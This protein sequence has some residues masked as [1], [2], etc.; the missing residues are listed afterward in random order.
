M[1]QPLRQLYPD[2]K[3]TSDGTA[4][5]EYVTRPSYV[6]LLTT[7]SIIV[8]H[9]LN[10]RSK[11]DTAHAW[12]TWCTPPGPQG[13]LWLRD[14]LPQYVPESRIFLYEY[15]STAAYG[16]DRDTFNGKANELLEAIRIERDEVESKP[17][18]LLGHSMGGLLIKQALITAHNNP[19]YTSIKDATTGLAFFATSHNGGD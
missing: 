11:K 9:G 19:K 17:I 1:A 15:N 13:R 18:L 3:S 10:P 2:P 6:T 4:K 8:V 7:S 14:D 12:D 16:K 5:V